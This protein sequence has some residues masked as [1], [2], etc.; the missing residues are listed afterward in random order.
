MPLSSKN[1]NFTGLEWPLVLLILVLS[2]MTF[3]RNLHWKDEFTLWADVLENSP[4]KWRPHLKVGLVFFREGRLPK[5][6]E[7]FKTALELNPEA[8][9]LHNNIGLS[10]Q[11][12]G[13]L[14]EAEKEFMLVMEKGKRSL[15]Y[16]NLGALYLEREDPE[17]ALEWFLRTID[18]NPNDISA[19]VNAGFTYGDLGQYRKAVEM[20]TKALSINPYYFDAH[21][22][23]G[24]AY[25]GLGQFDKA[26]F[27]WREYLRLT[28]QSELWRLDAQRHLLR[29]G[30]FEEGRR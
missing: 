12:M 28:P 24:L 26:V 27:H 1:T 17:M 3:M 7:K 30:P 16:L 21:Y 9:D 6:V 22:G 8:Y 23:L 2:L 11:R 15:A 18:T 29:L 25:E 4:L 13:L 10:Y 14:D 20:H 5:A 19:R